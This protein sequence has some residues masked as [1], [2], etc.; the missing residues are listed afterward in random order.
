MPESK[1]SSELSVFISDGK[2]NLSVNGVSGVRPDEFKAV[3]SAVVSDRVLLDID[4]TTGDKLKSLIARIRS[5]FS[6]RF[7]NK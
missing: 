3:E 5:Q 4:S 2:G 7:L 6:S 1:P